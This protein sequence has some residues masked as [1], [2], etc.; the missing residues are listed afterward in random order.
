MKNI[1]YLSIAFLFFNCSRELPKLETIKGIKLGL[2]YDSQKK[3]ADK[4]LCETSPCSYEVINETPNGAIYAYPKVFYAYYGDQK[5]LTQVSMVFSDPHNIPSI[6]G[7]FY[8]ALTYQQAQKI[9]KLYED[10]YGRGIGSFSDGKVTWEENGLSIELTFNDNPLAY[11]YIP[12][13]YG[14]MFQGKYW[15]EVDYEYND[16]LK[17]DID[18]KRGVDEERK[19][20]DLI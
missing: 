1:F 6:G 13:A 15:V 17:E 19:S 12:K 11:T 16:E 7:Q 10:K 14:W 18:F 2:T 3:K 8:P 4:V 20:N 5:I 9:F